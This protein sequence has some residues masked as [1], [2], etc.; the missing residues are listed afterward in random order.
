MFGSLAI[1]TSLGG[2]GKFAPAGG[3]RSIG[4][5]SPALTGFALNELASS[6]SVIKS[7]ETKKIAGFPS[8]SW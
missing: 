1:V 7:K 4:F 2:A 6:Y 3:F 5:A 8:R